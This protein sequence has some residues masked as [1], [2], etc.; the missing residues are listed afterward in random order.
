[1]NR[2]KLAAPLADI[3]ARAFEESSTLLWTKLK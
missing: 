2:A 1:M 3:A